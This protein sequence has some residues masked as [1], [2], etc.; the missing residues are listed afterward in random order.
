MERII[1]M[2]DF[3]EDMACDGKVSMLEAC[4][5]L[6]CL[7]GS[8]EVDTEL[9]QHVREQKRVWRSGGADLQAPLAWLHQP[10]PELVFHAWDEA[11]SAQRVFAQSM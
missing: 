1:G 4:V 10:F 8:G 9:H 6:A 2:R 5:H 11:H 3:P 7:P